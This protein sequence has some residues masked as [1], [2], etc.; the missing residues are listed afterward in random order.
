MT[1][2]TVYYIISVTVK[3]FILER[4]KFMKTINAKTKTSKILNVLQQGQSLTAAEARN[5]YG[6]LNLRAEVTRIRQSGYAVTMSKRKAGN[7]VNVTEYALGLPSREIIAL[8]Y[9]A[10]AKTKSAKSTAE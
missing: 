6:V 7:H 2:R 9:I 10:R 3:Q 8:G 5:R 1:G 4:R